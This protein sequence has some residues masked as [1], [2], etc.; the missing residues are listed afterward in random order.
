MKRQNACEPRI[1]FVDIGL[2]SDDEQKA[3]MVQLVEGCGG[4][5]A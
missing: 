4:A 5:P 2:V 1:D 3:F